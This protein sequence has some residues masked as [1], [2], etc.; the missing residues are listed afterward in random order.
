MQQSARIRL[1]VVD[2]GDELWNHPQPVV[3]VDSAQSHLQGRENLWDFAVPMIRGGGGMR[4]YVNK[5]V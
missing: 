2:A 1:A 5:V 3:H 4:G